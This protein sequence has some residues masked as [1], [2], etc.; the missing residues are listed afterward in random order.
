[1]SEKAYE[2]LVDTLFQMGGAVP[3]VR[4]DE[5][6][7]LIRE[8]FTLEEADLAGDMPPGMNPLEYICE[9]VGR[10]MENI[11]PLLEKMADK[12]LV[13]HRNRHQ[14][15]YYKLMSVLPGFFEFQFMK[16]N[17]TE[18]DR[19]LARLFKAYFDKAWG[20]VDETHLK[21]FKNLPPF[22]RV[23]PVEKEIT[24]G[25][26]VHPFEK[27]SEYIKDAEYVSVSTCYCRHHGELLDDPCDKPKENCLA[28]GP[29]AK[30]IDE[31]GYG[32]LIAEEEAL[33]ILDEAEKAGLVHMSSN[34]SKHIDF[35]CNC[36][37]CHCGIIKSFLDLE[38][39]AMGAVSNY[40][41][42]IDEEAC[43]G[44]ETCVEHC[45]LNALEV[46]DDLVQVDLKQCIGCGLCN[47]VC[48]EESLSMELIEDP[49]APPLDGKALTASVMESIQKTMEN[50]G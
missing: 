33:R 16:G 17:T 18:K 44:C 43:L 19:K 35:I 47:T 40:R 30:F 7:E 10:P 14:K 27:V 11:V 15:D 22:S 6:D 34:T 23:I 38:M 31:R 26:E 1:M 20:L 21:I 32:R 9:Q 48:P 24:A 42:K 39:P 13:I 28:F 12:G 50:Q 36:C 29:A 2:K 49:V 45:P 3:L 41:L 25:N 5:F 46:K 4:C 8:L 37:P